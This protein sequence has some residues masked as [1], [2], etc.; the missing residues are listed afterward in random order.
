MSEEAQMDALAYSSRML[1]W[2]P[3]GKLL[4]VITVLIVN[5]CTNSMMVP[6]ITLAIG[7]GLMAYSTNFKIPFFIA[8][9]LAEAILIL[10]IGC[11]M[12]SI[13]G[14][15]GTEAFWDT[16]ILW[17][18]VHMTEDS[19]NKA[20]LVLFRGFAGMAVMMSFATSTPIPHLSQALKQIHMPTEV[21]ELVVL[22]YR[23]GFL[24]IERMEVMWNAA[25][26]RMGFNGFMNTMRTTASIAVGIF[27]SSSNMADKAQIALECRN[28]KGVFPVYNE[29]PKVGLKWILVSAATFAGIFVFG[30]YTEGWVN[31]TD[32]LLRGLGII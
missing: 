7:L 25:A 23:Y 22:I 10:A 26:C 2:A 27:I 32:I 19:F 30:L 9:A 29:P 18:H 13:T 4:F 11:G 3:L 20:W 31:M 6:F 21:S 28:Y 8:L 15:A 24:L 12:I 1:H 17:M 5:I 16:N 14:D